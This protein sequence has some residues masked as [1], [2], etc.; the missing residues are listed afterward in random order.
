MA[1]LCPAWAMQETASLA[2]KPPYPIADTP[3]Q[4][5]TAQAG[6][7]QAGLAQAGLA[8]ALFDQAS[9]QEA[10]GDWESALHSYRASIECAAQASERA[11]SAMA[12]ARAGW[13]FDRQSE[14]SAALHCFLSSAEIERLQNDLPNLAM[15]LW[16][17]A[18]LCEKLMDYA[19]AEALMQEA[20]NLHAQLN[21]P[22]LAQLHARLARIRQRRQRVQSL[23]LTN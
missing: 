5:L 19:Q 10:T 16:Y 18:C 9:E 1:T 17:S 13:L 3:P 7:A 12:Y 22:Y 23:L 4:P 15:S 14:W 8:Q 20:L 6:L 11:L 2:L 21:T